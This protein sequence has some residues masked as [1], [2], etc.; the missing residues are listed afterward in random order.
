M[1][2]DSPTGSGGAELRKAIAASLPAAEADEA[3]A[4][5]VAIGAHL[6]DQEVTAAALAAETGAEDGWTGRKWQYA[7]RLGR[8]AG[9]SVRVATDAPTDP[10]TAADRVDR[11]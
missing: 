1:T 11:L 10:W 7:D 6:R 9:R 2:A 8:A 3:A 4:V 5:A